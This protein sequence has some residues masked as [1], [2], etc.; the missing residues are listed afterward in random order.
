MVDMSKRMMAAIEHLGRLPPEVQ[1]ARADCL[2]QFDSSGVYVL[3]A[4]EEAALDEADEGI[5][6][7]ELATGAEVDAAYA[8]SSR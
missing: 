1:D 3:S 7:G 5:A 2:E 6:R 8:R 4:E